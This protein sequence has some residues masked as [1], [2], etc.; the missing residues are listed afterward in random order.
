MIHLVRF[1]APRQLAVMVEGEVGGGAGSAPATPSTSAL[2]QRGPSYPA[3]ETR[4]V[5]ATEGQGRWPLNWGLLGV[6]DLPHWEKMG[7]L[8][9]PSLFGGTSSCPPGPR[10]RSV[11]YL[12]NQGG[13]E[14]EAPT[15]DCRCSRGAWCRSSPSQEGL[16]PGFGMKSG[17][18]GSGGGWPGRRDHSFIPMVQGA[19]TDSFC[20]QLFSLTVIYSLTE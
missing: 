8:W 20:Y 15:P 18:W 9:L 5:S 12:Q 1:T 13:S 11:P 17:V 4:L 14:P 10:H 16:G 2:I 6:S 19:N 3:Q 7:Y